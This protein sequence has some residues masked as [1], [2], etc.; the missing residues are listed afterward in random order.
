MHSKNNVDTEALSNIIPFPKEQAVGSENS[1]SIY[2]PIDAY[3]DASS[4]NLSQYKMYL[5]ASD[6]ESNKDEGDVMDDNKLLE[7]Y[8]DKIDQDQRDLKEDIW[9]SERRNQK[10]IEESEKRFDE[11]MSQIIDMMREQD[12]KFDKI[13]AKIDM[14]SKDV[15]DGLNDYRKFMWGIT[16]SIFLAI[17]AMIVSI[18]VA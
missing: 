1:S 12:K 4:M 16:I 6:N 11:K 18:I 5:Y 7:K 2:P 9:E 3:T 15:A 13:D 8:M 14:V 10:R 17:A